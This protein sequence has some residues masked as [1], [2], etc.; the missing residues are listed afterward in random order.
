MPLPIAHSLIG[1]GIVAALHP[2]PSARSYLP[3]LAGVILANAADFDFGFPVFLGLHGWHR[4]FTHSIGFA[5][6]FTLILTIWF[7]KN[8]LREALAFGLAYASHCVLDFATTR[9]RTRRRAF[10][11]VDDRAL[12]AALVRTVRIAVAASGNRDSDGN[13]A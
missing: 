2:Q 7:G 10:V 5:L 8:H 4:G 12:R 1:A 3:L 9:V 11:S 13:R 6:L